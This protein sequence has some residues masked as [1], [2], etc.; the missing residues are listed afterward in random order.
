M[1][2]TTAIYVGILLFVLFIFLFWMLTRGYA[3]KKYGTK[4]WKHWPNRLSYWQAAIMY[5]MGFT[6]IAL[7][8]LKWGNVLAF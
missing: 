1:E 6:F 8:L 2:Q 7:F 3:K 5:S 4:Q